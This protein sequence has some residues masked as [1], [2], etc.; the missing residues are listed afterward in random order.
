M[1]ESHDLDLGDGH[2]LD[3][4]EWQGQ[5]CGGIITHTTTKTETGFCSGAFWLA[6]F[7]GYE[8]GHPK[9]QMSGT[10]E[11]PTLN[12]SFMCHCKDHGFVRDGKWVRA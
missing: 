5:R 1:K 11:R 3:W 7:T 4:S 9:W 12:P 8:H 6:S 10:F 2:W